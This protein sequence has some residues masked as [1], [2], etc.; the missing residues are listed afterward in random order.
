MYSDLVERAEA[1]SERKL[2]KKSGDTKK[3]LFKKN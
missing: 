1:S 2:S 3:P